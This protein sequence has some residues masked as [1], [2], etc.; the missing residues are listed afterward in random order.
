MS[1]VISFVNCHFNIRVLMICVLILAMFI[2]GRSYLYYRF[3]IYPILDRYHSLRII[4][5]IITAIMIVGVFIACFM[6]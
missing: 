3:G 2:T 5:N 1:A 6:S 4:N